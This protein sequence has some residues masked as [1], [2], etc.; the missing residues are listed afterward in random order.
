MKLTDR[1]KTILDF[2]SRARM[3]DTDQ[4]GTIAFSENG[5]PAKRASECCRELVELKLIEGRRREIGKTKV[6]RL[7]KRGRDFCGVTYAPPHLNGLKVAH[8]LEVA[9]ILIQLSRWGRVGKW[10]TEPRHK[11]GKKMHSPDAFFVYGGKAY[12]LEVQ[13]SAISTARWGEKWAISSEYFEGGFYKDAPW[14]FWEGKTI[15]PMILVVTDTSEEKV[16]AGSRLQMMVVRDIMELIKSV[17][18]GA[19]K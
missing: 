18:E 15:R 7:S 6:W 4:I 19:V 5:S 17:R 8:N 14:Q 3:L 11:F 1:Q 13:R 10:V 16:R 12:L 2:L 9:E